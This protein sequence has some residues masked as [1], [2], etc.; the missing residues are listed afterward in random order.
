MRAFS[1]LAL[2][3]TASAFMAPMTPR[4]RGQVR[5]AVNDMM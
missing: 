4:G 1:L 2:I 5:M 3:G